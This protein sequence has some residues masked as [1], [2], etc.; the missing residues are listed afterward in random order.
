MFGMSFAE[1]GVILVLALV[2]LGPEK[3]PEVARTI[4]K[5]LREVRK[6]G[7]MLRDA[8]MLEDTP[9]SIK[10]PGSPA[11]TQTSSALGAASTA[12]HLGPPDD[13][14]SYHGPLDQIDDFGVA[15]TMTHDPYAHMPQRQ[16]VPLHP[17]EPAH[18]DG[19]QEVELS[20]A[21][22]QDAKAASAIPGLDWAP[23]PYQADD[24]TTT[25]HEVFLHEQLSEPEHHGRS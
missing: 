10:P 7:N 19:A 18:M 9:Y 4:G 20:P 8:I 24:E 11:S 6:A 2:L 12:H 13:F 3:L 25:R 15:G 17:Q 14:D 23:S 5:T 22:L 21:R 16:E 1:I